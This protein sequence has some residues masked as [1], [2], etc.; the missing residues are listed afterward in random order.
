MAG[1]GCGGVVSGCG[2]DGDGDGRALVC[3][4]GGTRASGSCEACGGG[5][6]G[7]GCGDKDEAAGVGGGRSVRTE[8]STVWRHA[9][10]RPV[11]DA[12]YA[13]ARRTCAVGR[14]A[15]RHWRLERCC[16]G[17]SSGGGASHVVAVAV[18]LAAALRSCEWR[19][20]RARCRRR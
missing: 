2:G 9:G 7:G 8:R 1:G 10:D 11:V 18:A 16:G 19:A 14:A 13:R 20:R 12:A 6:G 17:C 4:E 5:G 15:L 3:G